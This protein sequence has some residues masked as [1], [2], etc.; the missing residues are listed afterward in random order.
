M[1]RE[2]RFEFLH[3]GLG[4]L[5]ASDGIVSFHHD[6]LLIG[7][8]RV[9]PLLDIREFR[10]EGVDVFVEFLL[11]WMDLLAR[12]PILGIVAV[13]SGVRGGRAFTPAAH[14]H[15]VTTLNGLFHRVLNGSWFAPA[16]LRARHR[17]ASSKRIPRSRRS[18]FT[19]AFNALISSSR[20][21]SHIAASFSLSFS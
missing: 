20:R 2:V 15:D 4:L 14:A 12:M 13:G 6:I 5:G 1:S 17:L 7:V 16:A 11:Q 19:R 3:A 18:S 8:S 9:Q 10:F 21:S